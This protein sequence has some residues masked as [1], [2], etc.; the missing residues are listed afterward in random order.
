MKCGLVILNYKD[1]V[2]TQKLLDAVKDFS[3]IDNIAVVDN[4]SPNESYEVLKKNASSKITV[5]QS[6]RNGGYS[7]G[8]NIGI[9]YLIEHHSPDI[10][11]I[12][13]PDVMFGNELVRR[14]K[15]TFESNPDYAIL[16]GFQLN[17]KNETG[18]HPFWED[19]GN[20]SSILQ[21]MAYSL[22]ISPF[23]KL[24]RKILCMKN[25]N[26]YRE[27]CG[28]IKNS[29]E[30]LNQVW[31]VEGSLFFIR[32]S[33]FESVGLFDERIF[34]FGEEDV[35]A[36]KIKNLGRKTGVINDVTYIHNHIEHKNSNPF[37]FSPLER[38]QIFHFCNYVTESKILHAMYITL[39]YLSR[40]KHILKVAIKKLISRS[41]E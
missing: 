39:M 13:N 4:C 18:A 15:E 37:K 1:Y 41:N 21:S 22:T 26:K 24:F 11:G 32:T 33:D 31:A 10:I 5:L 16:T 34:M 38:G 12:A 6:D 17:A 20:A 8:N 19:N 14:I 7:Y 40:L 23:V 3:E 9:R 25:I 28:R 35:L 27:Y 36:K 29:P 2:L 30:N